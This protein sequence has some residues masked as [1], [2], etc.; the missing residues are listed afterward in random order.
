M[1]TEEE[2][3]TST[4]SLSEAGPSTIK[5]T[6]SSSESEDDDDPVITNYGRG[7]I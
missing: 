1:S 5:S 6:E 7:F 3:L 4:P 2:P